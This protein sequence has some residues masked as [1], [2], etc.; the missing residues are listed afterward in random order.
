MDVSNDFAA[1][2]LFGGEYLYYA[3]MVDLIKNWIH[4][5]MQMGT[6]IHYIFKKISFLHFYSELLL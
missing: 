1:E 2:D 5:I 6:K 4:T 3:I